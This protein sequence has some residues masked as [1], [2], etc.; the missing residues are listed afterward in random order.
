MVQ[1]MLYHDVLMPSE[2]QQPTMATLDTLSNLVNTDQQ[3]YK[4]AGITAHFYRKYVPSRV[5]ERGCV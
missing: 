2:L 1:R 3:T 5:R 4:P